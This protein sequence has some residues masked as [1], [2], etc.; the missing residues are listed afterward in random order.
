MFLKKNC[1]M[2]ETTKKV[3]GFSMTPLIQDGQEIT[4][5][6][7]Y[8]TCGNKAKKGDIILYKYT[9]TDH[10]ALKRIRGTDKDEIELK[11]GTL[12]INGETMRN[13][14]NDTY[15]FTHT[16]VQMLSLYITKKHLP[17]NAYFIFGDNI[18]N[19]SDSRKF[20]AVS[21]QDFLGYVVQID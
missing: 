19:S 1:P 7:N 20:G 12:Q 17:K 9:G 21:D 3:Q 18:K 10:P 6:E 14:V 2:N 13:S 15:V 16:E 5:V 11:N 4:V 8:F